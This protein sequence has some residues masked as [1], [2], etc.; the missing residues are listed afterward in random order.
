MSVTGSLSS[1]VVLGIGNILLSDE[2]IGV[3]VVE[4]LLKV[5]VPKEAEV[6]DGG[7]SGADLLDVICNRRKVIVIDAVDADVP[8]GT[9]L[10]MKP[11]EVN[12]GTSGGVSLHELGIIETL[13]MAKMLDSSPEEVVLIGIKPKEIG[14]GLELSP[15]IAAVVP[16]VVRLV[17]QEIS[18]SN[19]DRVS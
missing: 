15:E 5:Q 14:C 4:E 17:M 3:R 7:T 6:I 1:I 11:E 10:R 12:G 18:T 16:A 2:G 9:I 8:P 13:A 19:R